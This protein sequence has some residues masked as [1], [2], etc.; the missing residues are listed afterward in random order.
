MINK[1]FSLKITAF[2]GRIAPEESIL[3]GY[4][5]IIES[6]NLQVPLPHVL[7]IISSKKRQYKKG[8][9]Q[10]FTP[11]HL[12]ENN[13]YKQL[14]FALKYEG[15]DL[16]VLKKLFEEITSEEA[17]FLFK[18]ESLGQYSRR[19]WF[20]YEWLLD[21]RLK[22]PDLMTGNYVALLDTKLQYAISDGT[23]SKRHRIINNLPGTK[24]FCPLIK[25]TEKLD[26]YI[27]SDL[28]DQKNNYLKGIHKDILQRASAFL[29][30]KDSKASFNI[31]GE[32]PKG[33]RAARWG[34]AIA[35]AGSNDLNKKEFLRLQ[36]LVIENDR[37]VE[38]GFRKEGGFVGQHDRSTE[39]P[40]PD[41]IS[42]RWQD[43]EYL[44]NGLIATNNLLLL[45]DFNAVL[46]A[47]IIAFG[48]VF[49]HP[50]EDGNGRIHRY[51]VHHILA[52]KHFAHQ[53]IIF[54]VSASIL[55]QIDNYRKV[56][57]SYSQPLLDFIDWDETENHNVEVKNETADFYRYF[58]ITKQTEFLYD[59]VNDTILNIIPS[60]ITYL[61]NYDNFKRFVDDEFEMPDKTIA[62]LV[63][64]LEQNSGNL[65]KR[66]IDR[67]FADLN[68]DE[69]LVI[70]KKFKEIFTI[71]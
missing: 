39:E 21:K 30:L 49:I 46:T 51:L 34:Q 4:G 48:F 3:V 69:V 55:D 28:A 9:W 42:A 12:P 43:L 35:Q 50:L 32:S 17:E 15:V 63:N 60:E 64:F 71:T 18:V 22:L 58:D 53:G 62:L 33:K 6:Y 2:H 27:A 61:K 36:Q 31:E 40:I 44:I 10:V 41:H 11:R 56:L 5:A 8:Q 20:L 13:L 38:M 24:D 26:S 47:T 57:E 25:R 70:E 54:P 37:F 65:S 29:L 19:L 23:K 14:I 67:E 16:L 66:A 7:S 59:C 1:S 68:D 52:K 45:T